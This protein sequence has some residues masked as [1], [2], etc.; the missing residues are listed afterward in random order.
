MGISLAV[1]YGF[2]Q[3]IDEN[4]YQ[5]EL[6]QELRD[7]RQTISGYLRMQSASQTVVEAAFEPDI[8][9]AWTIMIAIMMLIAASQYREGAIFSV[10]I[11]VVFGLYFYRSRNKGDKPPRQAKS[12]PVSELLWYFERTLKS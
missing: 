12:P 3:R 6:Y 2:I 7:G 5:F 9:D 1:M 4:T 11:L 8:N 10:I